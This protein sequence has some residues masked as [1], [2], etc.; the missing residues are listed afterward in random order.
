MAEESNGQSIKI[1]T[2]F[3]E[4]SAAGGIVIIVIAL[5]IIA[6]MSVWEH[7]KRSKEADEILCGIRLN[8]FL[9]T[10]PKGEVTFDRV[11][12]EYWSC[13]PPTIVNRQKP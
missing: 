12:A 6:A 8:S 13:L 7:Y 4:V 9:Y 10:L 5:A 1:K 3:G 2:A 11:P